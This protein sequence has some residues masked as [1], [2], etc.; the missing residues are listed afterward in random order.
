MTPVLPN[1]GEAAASPWKV[2]DRVLVHPQS[3]EL[4][5]LQN[6]PGTIVHIFDGFLLG[7]L[8]V[9]L[10]RGERIA[11]SGNHVTAAAPRP[12]TRGGGAR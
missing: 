10:D 3:P 11:L 6:E 9:R 8:D 1:S 12:N 5:E 2:G 4:E 7:G